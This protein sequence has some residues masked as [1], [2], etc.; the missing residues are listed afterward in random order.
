MGRS[1]NKTQLFAHRTN[2]SQLT[3]GGGLTPP[4]RFGLF[5]GCH[6]WAYVQLS[7]YMHGSFFFCR[8]KV[9]LRGEGDRWVGAVFETGWHTNEEPPSV[10][11]RLD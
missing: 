4:P 3:A 2:Y 9:S 6:P 1:P 8:A 10:R 11:R 5:Q 7:P